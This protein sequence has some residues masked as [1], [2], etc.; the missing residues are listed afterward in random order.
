MPSGRWQATYPVVDGPRQKAPTTFASK[1]DADLWLA[2]QQTKIAGGEW[3]D[4]RR[5]QIRFDVLADNYFETHEG[6][7]RR[8]TLTRDKG[9]SDRYLIPEFGAVAICTIDLEIIQGWVTRMSRSGGNAGKPLKPRTVIKANQI[10]GKVL[11]WA[12]DNKRIARNPARGVKYPKAA[13]PDKWVLS[14]AEV[15]KL[16]DA[17]D[18]RYRAMVFLLAYT[19]LRIGEALALRVQDMHL[20]SEEVQVS[21]RVVD[22]AGHLDLDQPKTNE[23]IRTVPVPRL[24]T[25][26]LVWHLRSRGLG[27]ND[28]LFPAPEGGHCRYNN[29]RRRAWRVESQGVVYGGVS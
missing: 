11:Q 18:E 9:Y 19:G 28:P 25:D 22:L 5:G 8:T 6:A 13:P 20:D 17:I 12:V 2:K 21:K 16:A 23:A 14:Q 24:V 10:L 4:P 7:L 15:E 1:V 26:E 3:T 27:P 29:W